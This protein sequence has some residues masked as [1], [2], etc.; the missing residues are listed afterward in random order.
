MRRWN[1]WADEAVRA[2]LAGEARAL[3]AAWPG[4]S[5]AAQDAA[6]AQACAGHLPEGAVLFGPGAHV[7]TLGKQVTR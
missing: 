6:F 4:W 7:D 2:S 5:A 3:P 1:G